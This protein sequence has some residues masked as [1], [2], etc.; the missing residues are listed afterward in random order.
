MN[1]I[2]RTN[3]LIERM[4]KILLFASAMALMASCAEMELG[5]DGLET[6]K[7]PAGISFSAGVDEGVN[8]RGEWEYSSEG[9]SMFWYAEADKMDFYARNAKIGT[10]EASLS[11]EA[12]KATDMAIYKATRSESKGFFTADDNTKIIT[13]VKGSNGKWLAPEFA[14]V[15][16]STTTVDVVNSN[17][18]ATLPKLNAQD[19]TAVNGSSTLENVFMTGTKK[20]DASTIKDY[21]SGSDLL[22]DIKLERKM[23]LLGFFL[24]GYNAKT[25][26]KL[27]SIKLESLGEMKEDGKADDTKK[28]V[29]DYGTDAKWN[30]NE[31]DNAK[32][33]TAGSTTTANSVTLKING[34]TAGLEWGNGRDF[35]AFMTVAP[36]DRSGMK[37]GEKLKITYAFENTDVEREIV[38]TNSWETGHHF[39]AKDISG[40]EGFDLSAEPY[41]VFGKSAV[42]TLQLN[43][44]FAGSIESLTA[45]IGSVNVNSFTSIVANKSLSDAD[46]KYVGDKFT[47]LVDV[48]LNENTSIPAFNMTGTNVLTTL[49]APKVISIAEKAFYKTDA[50]AMAL[51][52]C[53]LPAYNFTNANVTPALLK[54]ASLKVAD[55][56]AVSQ[57]APAFPAIGMTLQG[58][59]VLETVTVGS[60]VKV[61]S[62]AFSGCSELKE[63]KI[64]GGSIAN[65]GIELIGTYA[66]DKC[67]KLE[68]ISISNKDIPDGSFN[69]CSKL[70]EINDAAGNAIVPTS[71]GA[72]AFA[73]TVIE[74][75]DLSKA[76][77]IDSGAFKD[78]KSLVGK[79]DAVSNVNVLKVDAITVLNS[80]VFEN[81]SKL[82]YVG[83]A[84]VTSVDNDFLKGTAC[85]QIEFK[86]AISFAGVATGNMSVDSFGTIASIKTGTTLFVNGAQPGVLEATLTLKGKTSDQAFIFKAI[87]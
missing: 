64:V 23:P 61:G 65:K 81:C 68:T 26:G 75:I 83:F 38:I 35:T 71:I 86:K 17:L 4:K 9:W 85:T 24:K 46:F 82:T 48:T 74:D 63:V 15:W 25:Y 32:A 59:A 54:A 28:S 19:Q 67:V 34:G 84:N 3:K 13:P 49:V 47:A 57:I 33:Y 39:Y 12:W 51:E 44:N 66:F 43:S 45:T 10:T 6:S 16:P 73:A 62:K 77:T 31:S 41:I 58:F 22:I 69:G 50:P 70:A 36:V 80:S 72:N 37:Y 53:I 42:K 79:K 87:N 52:M 78:C 20:V 21:T 30:I 29:L 8:T 56:S 5:T 11:T 76:E 14:Y 1:T 27:L 7:L 18:V 40:T 2:K 60:G 55:L